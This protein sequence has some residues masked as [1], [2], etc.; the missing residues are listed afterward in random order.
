MNTNP[1]NASLIIKFSF[2]H[3]KFPNL[4][5]NLFDVANF[6]SSSFPEMTVLLLAFKQNRQVLFY[7]QKDI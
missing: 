1:Q 3:S 6:V 4:L 5:N 2:L 7:F